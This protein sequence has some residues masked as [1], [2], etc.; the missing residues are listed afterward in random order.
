M[1]LTNY[2]NIIKLLRPKYYNL[3]TR[4]LILA[5][6]PLLTKPLWIDIV[7]IFLGEIKIGIIGKYDCLIGLILIIIALTYNTV[8]KYLDL[9]HEFPNIP[10]YKEVEQDMFTD[11][12]ALC[13][14]ILPILKDNESIFKNCGPNSGAMDTG[15]LRVDLTF[16][17]HLKKDSIVPNNKTIKRLIDQ[18]AYLI[19]NEYQDIFNRLKLHI[20]AFDIHVNNPN[21]SYTEHQFPKEITNII[22]NECYNSALNNKDLL[23]IKRWLSKRLKKRHIESGFLF[24]SILLYPHK[25]KDVDIVILTDDDDKVM[26]AIQSLKFDFKEKFK[27]DLHITFFAKINNSN[28]IAFLDK[29]NFKY[30]L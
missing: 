20:D 10:A 5:A 28:C 1:N 9:K 11:F 26:I 17:N 25:A 23:C 14:T 12:G 15:E 2:I 19:P 4:I 13:Q 27:R 18:N 3:I 24:G 16:W 8:H 29:N 22:E 21:F 30:K 6:I 7:N